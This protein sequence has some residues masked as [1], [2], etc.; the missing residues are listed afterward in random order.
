M[1]TAAAAVAG[2]SVVAKAVRRG[3]DHEHLRIGHPGG[4]MEAGVDYGRQEEKLMINYA[5]GIRTANL[6]MEGYFFY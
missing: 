1:C 2:K 3:F 6:L 5:S 4:I